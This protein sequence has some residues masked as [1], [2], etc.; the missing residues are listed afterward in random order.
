[1]RTLECKALL[2]SCMQVAVPKIRATL[3]IPGPEFFV[4]MI[5]KIDKDFRKDHDLI[6]DHV[7]RYCRRRNE[8]LCPS[9]DSPSKSFL[10]VKGSLVN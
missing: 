4:Y 6:R 8:V 3:N 9:W 1:M 7:Y 10:I 2:T 5:F